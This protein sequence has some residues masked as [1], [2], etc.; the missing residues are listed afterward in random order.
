MTALDCVIRG[1][2]S[3]GEEF[4]KFHLLLFHEAYDESEGKQ[5]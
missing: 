3:S 5:Q 2:V 1:G 4:E